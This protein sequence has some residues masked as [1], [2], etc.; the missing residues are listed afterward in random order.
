[1]RRSVRISEPDLYRNRHQ[2]L[3]GTA[4]TVVLISTG[5]LHQVVHH[6]AFGSKARI[7]PGR[8]WTG[9]MPWR[10]RL[11]GRLGFRG[12]TRRTRTAD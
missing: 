3:V 8:K 11:H 12:F 1:M 2:T 6:R 4:V 10:T 9:G 7:D 5:T